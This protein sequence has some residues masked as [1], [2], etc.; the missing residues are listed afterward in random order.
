M[1][2]LI[3]VSSFSHPDRAPGCDVSTLLVEKS[4]FIINA[5]L[6][7]DFIFSSNLVKYPNYHLRSTHRV[8]S[9][10]IINIIYNSCLVR[11]MKVLDP[12]LLDPH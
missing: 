11:M 1:W 3:F 5:H 8:L 2:F 9:S 10:Y 6:R 4:V 7:D 12:H